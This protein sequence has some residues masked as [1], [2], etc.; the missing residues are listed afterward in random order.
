MVKVEINETIREYVLHFFAG[1]PKSPKQNLVFTFININDDQCLL[2]FRH[3]FIQY[4][5]IKRI[6]DIKNE[7]KGILNQLKLNIE[8][9]LRNLEN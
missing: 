9:N 5:N 6:S 8:E 1:V 4:V 2:K 7:K 3:N